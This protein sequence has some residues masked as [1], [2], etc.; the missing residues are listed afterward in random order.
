MV[1]TQMFMVATQSRI[2]RQ[3]FL[4]RSLQATVSETFHGSNAAGQHT[5]TTSSIVAR[6]TI[7]YF[8][9]VNRKEV[10]SYKQLLPRDEHDLLSGFMSETGAQLNLS[11]LVLQCPPL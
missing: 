6:M 2:Y 1:L 10:L 11:F 4:C 8:N 5:E 3:L 7:P 9:I